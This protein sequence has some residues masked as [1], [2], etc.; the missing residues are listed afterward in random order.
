MNSE[1]NEKKQEQAGEHGEL[2]EELIE[3]IDFDRFAES[4][5]R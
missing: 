3:E 5:K 2:P 4:K 1:Q